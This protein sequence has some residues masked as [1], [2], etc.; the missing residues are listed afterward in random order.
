MEYTRIH[1]S[2]WNH[3]YKEIQVNHGSRG[4]HAYNVRQ[5]I[6]GIKSSELC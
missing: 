1:R 5:A 3:G 2:R 6:M 4:S